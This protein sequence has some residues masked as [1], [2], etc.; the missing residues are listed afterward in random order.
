MAG[1]T[2]DSRCRGRDEKSGPP[3]VRRPVLPCAAGFWGV[4]CARKPRRVSL[5]KI[6]HAGARRGEGYRSGTARGWGPQRRVLIA[7]GCFGGATPPKPRVDRCQPRRILKWMGRPR[8]PDKHIE[9]AVRYALE[10]GWRVE[11]SQGHAWGHLLCP[12]RSR[13]G[14]I[15]PVWSTPRSPE[16]HARWIR[17]EIEKCDHGAAGQGADHDQ[18]D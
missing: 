2:I 16:R 10:R 9:A 7:V 4:D 1:R 14:H 8:H 11:I 17:R 15:V 3:A 12:R 13:D 5:E 18:Q 6:P